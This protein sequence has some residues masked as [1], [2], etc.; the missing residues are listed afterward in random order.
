MQNEIRLRSSRA[1]GVL[2]RRR[3]DV[4]R[5]VRQRTRVERVLP[6]CACINGQTIQV[7][8][9]FVE[10]VSWVE[11]VRHRHPTCWAG[12][13]R[14]LAHVNGV[15]DVIAAGADV[16]DSADTGLEF[17]QG[18][19]LEPTP[20]VAAVAGLGVE[21]CGVAFLVAKGRAEFAGLDRGLDDRR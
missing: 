9:H 1:H 15:V 4:N 16:E 7:D 17:C 18:W 13:C 8:V 5:H 11:S 3:V 10:E 21:S 14:P 20:A 2:Q 12:N 6:R 19:S